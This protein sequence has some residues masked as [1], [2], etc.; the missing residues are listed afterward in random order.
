M[1]DVE[2]RKFE[3]NFQ[4]FKMF[5]DDWSESDPGFDVIYSHFKIYTTLSSVYNTIRDLL[6]YECRIQNEAI[7]LNLNSI[8]LFITLKKVGF[9]L[10]DPDFQNYQKRILEINKFIEFINCNNINQIIFCGKNIN[11]P[12]PGMETLQNKT[13]IDFIIYSFKEVLKTVE[14]LEE[15]TIKLNDLVLTK[16]LFEK[17][18]IETSM[19]QISKRKRGGQ[20]SSRKTIIKE[21]KAGIVNYFDSEPTLRS[22]KPGKKKYLGAMLLVLTSLLDRENQYNERQAKSKNVGYKSYRDYL[23]ISWS[24]I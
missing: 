7:V 22:L 20:V 15:E 23:N 11:N 12:T 4:I 5:F 6:Y 13:L 16:R 21:I 1:E 24:S 19:V 18:Q 17:S 3:P 2:Y 9:R 8:I 14:D 10:F